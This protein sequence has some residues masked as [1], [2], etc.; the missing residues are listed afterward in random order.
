MCRRNR[1]GQPFKM[2]LPDA[3]GCERRSL[4][5]SVRNA[6]DVGGNAK[7]GRRNS[8]GADYQMSEQTEI[9]KT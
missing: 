8:Y 5:G 4:L 7:I 1:D 6:A 9:E 2:D 3:Y